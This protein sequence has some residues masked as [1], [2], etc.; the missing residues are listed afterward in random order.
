M[1]HFLPCKKALDASYVAT[2]FLI[3]VV[4]LHGI[5]KSITSDIDVCSVNHFW[6]ILWKKF[7]TIAI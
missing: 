1:E 6:K 3:E 2:L 7:D 4:H 5:S